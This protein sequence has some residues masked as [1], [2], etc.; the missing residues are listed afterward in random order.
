MFVYMPSEAM[1]GGSHVKDGGGGDKESKPRMKGEGDVLSSAGLP[2]EGS[3]DVPYPNPNATG[4]AATCNVSN[5]LL[6]P[7]KT[8]IGESPPLSTT[9]VEV[10]AG[11]A[12]ILVGS[13]CESRATS[14]MCPAKAVSSLSKSLP[15]IEP[16][17]PPTVLPSVCDADE[18]AATS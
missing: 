18:V 8:A 13:S 4:V 6:P 12:K 14:S 7:P 3:A 10:D 1:G 15:G 16:L 5:Q 2:P 11:K 17:L 9:A